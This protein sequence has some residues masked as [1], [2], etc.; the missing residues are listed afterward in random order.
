MLGCLPL[1]PL[2]T[3]RSLHPLISTLPPLQPL[4][5]RF[6]GYL[7]G[8]YQRCHT[9]VSDKIRWAHQ[10]KNDQQ[11][12]KTGAPVDCTSNHDSVISVITWQ[13]LDYNNRCFILLFLLLFSFFFSIRSLLHGLSA[14]VVHIRMLK[15]SHKVLNCKTHLHYQ[16]RFS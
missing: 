3:L 11:F 10:L 12:T 2:V 6:L 5:L 15:I 13:N 14:A 9:T 4:T 8:L 7:T 1:D 16:L